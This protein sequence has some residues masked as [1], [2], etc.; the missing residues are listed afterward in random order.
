MI[1]NKENGWIQCTPTTH[2][3]LQRIKDYLEKNNKNSISKEELASLSK[4]RQTIVNSSVFYYLTWTF[5]IMLTIILGL[6][7]RFW[8]LKMKKNKK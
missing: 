7:I 3:Q 5:G 1:I 2:P 8:L 6:A 4:N